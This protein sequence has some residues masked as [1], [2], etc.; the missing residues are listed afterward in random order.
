MANMM[1]Q[2]KENTIGG[3]QKSQVN[4]ENP[5]Q[6]YAN[7]PYIGYDP[8]FMAYPYQ[9]NNYQIPGMNFTNPQG[10]KNVKNRRKNESY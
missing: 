8:R 3:Q 2:G 9:F 10:K 1:S 7:Y 5:Y 6:N 4:T